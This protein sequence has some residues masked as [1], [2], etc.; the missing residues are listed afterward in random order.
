MVLGPFNEKLTRWVLLGIK[1]A[2]ELGIEGDPPS[3]SVS[4][5]L[6]NRVRM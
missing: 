4:C 2:E 5:R 6:G 3:S 1:T